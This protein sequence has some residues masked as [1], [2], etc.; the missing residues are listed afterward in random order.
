MSV[1]P[2]HYHKAEFVSHQWNTGTTWTFPWDIHVTVTEDPP[3]I[4]SQGWTGTFVCC[5]CDVVYKT[6]NAW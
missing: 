1:E 6:R 3:Q 5:I 2:V 4:V